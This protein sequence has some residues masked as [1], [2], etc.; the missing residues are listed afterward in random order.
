MKPFVSKTETL[1][2]EPFAIEENTAYIFDRIRISDAIKEN[3][4]HL[5]KSFN[6]FI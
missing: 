3:K 2:S 4:E 5:E 1:T 6:S